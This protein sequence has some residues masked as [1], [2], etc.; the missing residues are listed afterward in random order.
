MGGKNDYK[1][2]TMRTAHSNLDIHSLHFMKMRECFRKAFEE[3]SI[4]PMDVEVLM[5]KIDYMKVE[6]LNE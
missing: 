5:A 1:G 6:V 4:E 3:S 2:M